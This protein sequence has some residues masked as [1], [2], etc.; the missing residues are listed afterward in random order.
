MKHLPP[1]PWHLIAPGTVVLMDAA[2]TRTVL[3]IVGDIH[4]ITVY[5]EGLVPFRVRGDAYAQPVELDTADAIGN[6]FAAGFT[7]TP[8]KGS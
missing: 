3:Q 7:V 6:L 4:G 2:E 5:A 1:T 8:I